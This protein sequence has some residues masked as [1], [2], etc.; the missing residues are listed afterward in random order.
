VLVGAVFAVG[1]ESLLLFECLFWCFWCL[2]YC[3]F[4][5]FFLLWL[6]LNCCR[7]CWQSWCSVRCVRNIRGLDWPALP[8]SQIPII[9]GSTFSQ[10]INGRLMQTSI[11]RASTIGLTISISTT[12]TTITTI[13]SSYLTLSISSIGTPLRSHPI[14]AIPSIALSKVSRSVEILLHSM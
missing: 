8:C 14:A 10:S 2:S 7:L 5:G 9:P 13:T 11:T 12:I 6:I 4:I 3:R 1:P